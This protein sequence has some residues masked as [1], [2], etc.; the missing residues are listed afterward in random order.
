ML[1]GDGQIN[2]VCNDYFRNRTFCRS[3]DGKI[4]LWNLYNLLTG[5]NKSSYIDNFPDRSVN[6]YSL[7]RELYASVMG[8]KDCWFLS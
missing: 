7:T 2:L 6:A 4:N 3:E 5:A 8:K 1:F